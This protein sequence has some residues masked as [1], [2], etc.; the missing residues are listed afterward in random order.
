M[1]REIKFRGMGLG[2]EWHYGMLAH[3]TSTKIVS[4]GLTGYFISNSVGAPFAYPVRPETVGQFTG[5]HD[6]NGKEIYEGDIVRLDSGDVTHDSVVEWKQGGLIVSWDNGFL[7]GDADLQL[8]GWAK[9][10]LSLEIIGNIYENP[11]LIK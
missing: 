10:E 6:K 2:G 7:G 1:N 3:V 5:L 11:E 8:I 4:R 9:D